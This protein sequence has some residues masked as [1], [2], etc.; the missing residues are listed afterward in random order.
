LPSEIAP[1]AAIT[2]EAGGVKVVVRI[3]DWR[4]GRLLADLVGALLVGTPL[5]VEFL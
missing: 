5:F 2:I 4:G 1:S 3:F